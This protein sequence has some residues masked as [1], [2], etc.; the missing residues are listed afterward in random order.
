MK[1][2]TDIVKLQQELK[3]L[4][5]SQEVEIALEHVRA[6]SMAMHKSSDLHTVVTEVFVNLEQLGVEANSA[7]LLERIDDKKYMHF[8]VAANGQVYPRIVNLPSVD[9]TFFT[10]FYKARTQL[11]DFFTHIQ[12]KSEK[13][14][15]FRHY[16]KNSSHTDVPLKRQEFILS[17]A[18]ASR[19]VVLFEH[20]ALIVMRY[21][22]LAYTSEEN[23][24]IKRMGSVFQQSYK[25]YLDL[26][27]AEAQTREAQIEGALERLRSRSMAMHKSEELVEVVKVLDIEVVALGIDTHGSQIVTDLTGWK[28]DG[29]CYSWFAN[30]ELGYMEK[31]YIPFIDCPITSKVIDAFEKGIEFYTEQISKADKDRFFKRLYTYSDLKRIPVERQDFMFST[32]GLSRAL[33]LSSNSVLIFQ[34]LNNSKFTEEEAA[35]FKRFGTVFNQTYTRFLDLQKSEAQAREAQIETSLERVRARS[36]G[37][38]ESEQLIEVISLLNHELKNLGVNHSSA[39]LI[40]DF[41]IENP[42]DGMTLWSAASGGPYSKIHMPSFKHIANDNYFKA[43]RENK[44]YYSDYYSKKEKDSYFR[45]IFKH[46]DDSKIAK[47]R[48]KLIFDAKGWSRACVP[49]ENSGLSINRYSDA[50]FSNEDLKLIRRFGNVFEQAYTRFLDLQKAEAQTRE[51]QIEGALEKVRSRSLAMHKPDELQEVIAVVAEK[52]QELGVILDAGGAI[53]CTYFPDNKDV[54]HWISAPDFSHSGSYFIPYFDDKT[55]NE[56]WDSKNSGELYFSQAYPQE[57]KNKFF[58]YAFEH[59]DYRNFPDEFKQLILQST[60]YTL[61]FAWQKNSAILIPSHSGIVPSERDAEIIKRFAKVFEQAYIRFMDLQKAEAQARKAQVESALERVRSQAMAMHSSDD[62]SDAIKTFYN[63]F[64]NLSAVPVLRLGVSLLK[65]DSHICEVTTISRTVNMELQE[66][67]GTLDFSKNPFLKQG[68]KHWLSQNDYLLTLK[69]AKLKAY[70]QHV[71]TQLSVPEFSKN[72][73]QYIYFQMFTEGSFYVATETK[74]EETELNVY[75]KFTSVLSLTYKRYKDLID[76]EAR[77]KEALKQSSLDRVR[78]E[79]ASMR[80]TKDLERITPLVWKELKTLGVPFFRCGIFIIREDEQMVHAYLSSPSGDSLAALHIGFDDTEVA[81]IQPA[82]TNWRLQKDYK[83]TWNQSEFIKNSKT[84]MKYGEIESVQ[85][86]QAGE[87]PPEKLVLQLVPF[88]QGMLYVGNSEP[89]IEEHIDLIKTLAQA[90]SIAYSRYEDFIQLEL[91]KV[92][93]ENA[94]SEL[95][96]TQTQ[97]IQSEKMASLGELTAGIAHE[98]Q[99]PLNFVNNFSEVSKELLDEMLEAIE[100]GDMEEVHAIMADVIQNLEK[101]NHHGKRADAIVKGMLQHSRASGDKKEATDI[102]KLADEYL[103]LAYHGLRA[104]DKAF[105]A[106]IKTDFDESVGKID[107]I[108][109]DIGRVIL[110]LITNAFY[111]VNEKKMAIGKNGLDHGDLKGL[112]TYEPTVIVSTK[113]L[114]PPL[115]AGGERKGNAVQISIKDNGNGVPDKIKEKIFQPFFTTKPTG[116]GTGLGLSM[117]YDI[118]TKGHGGELTVET[119]ENEGLSDSNSGRQA[120]TTFSIILPINTI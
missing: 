25:R 102:N 59:S 74:L 70:F 21:N 48:K 33:A 9:N 68:Y 104:K 57:D 84:F 114:D 82:L 91:A 76:A 44:S 65:K 117:S 69:G 58:E 85:K 110:N 7:L 100:N 15:M 106:N 61:S 96:T 92:S 26:Q 13:D 86:Y 42:Q 22:S 93:V 2:E 11:E 120:G 119:I 28:L 46:I 27:K 90:F 108:P 75:K 107:V 97:L 99:N 80:N 118:V 95:Q 71:N 56:A 12:S 66:A 52:L 55:F 24:I 116:Q 18:G 105:N 40:T 49:M 50:L 39:V 45:F 89:L 35:I 17:T 23:E 64:V 47:E 14:E 88:K 111:A 101:I 20:T 8:W 34:R 79:I 41:D 1:T 81:I 94:L 36:M 29:G 62:L 32:P 113:L 103:R 73:V 98:I 83:E 53:I 51:A 31:F 10:R 112:T 87:T 3:S 6:A 72:A 43:R 16:F 4:K 60:D 109:Q 5:R 38:H 54:I 63:E 19:S 78:A 77:E 30:K 67:R 115:E 37:M